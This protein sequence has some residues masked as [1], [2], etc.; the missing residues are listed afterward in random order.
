VGDETAPFVDRAEAGKVLASSLSGYRDRSDVLVLA[1]TRGGVPVGYEVAKSLRARLDV[2]VVR[3]LGFP[4][5]PELAMGAIGP[6]GIRVLEPGVVHG[7]GIPDRVVDAVTSR[8][9]KE[10]ERRERFYRDELP[11]ADPRGMTVIVVDD[12]IATGSSMRAAI[13]SVRA[14][15]AARVIAAVPVAPPAAR[16]ELS[17]LADEFVCVAEPVDFVAVGQWYVDFGQTSDEEVRRLL[18]QSALEAESEGLSP[19]P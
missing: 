8:E 1:L 2:I 17:R 14:R 6:G 19:G 18:A 13:A 7:L 4:G 11:P 10:L 15:G 12:G 5:Q 3:K 9:A 16:R